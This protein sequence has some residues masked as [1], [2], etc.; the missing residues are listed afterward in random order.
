MTTIAED[1]APLARRRRWE[2][3]PYLLI[4]PT[5]VYLGVFFVWP[6]IQGFGLALRD[7]SGGWTTSAFET[8]VDDAA[9]DDAI[10]FTFL[11][12]LIIVPIQLVLALGMALLLNARLRGGG[13][14]LYIFLLPLAI[15]DL[16]A[17]I[18]WSAIFTE[19]GYLN[20]ILEG[21]GVL[22]QPFIFLDPTSRTQLVIAVAAA[23]IWRSTTF[24]MVILFAGLQAIPKDYT[25]AAEV[26]GAGF[27]QRVRHV[28]FPMLKPSIQVALLLRLIFA[29]EVFAVVIALTG[30]G[31]TVLAAEAYK[32]QATNENEHVAA[33]YSMVILGL[34][35]AAAA[36]VLVALRTPRER[37]LR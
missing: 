28:I 9:F 20:T 7:E 2:G 24:M 27:F 13:L 11:L 23:E 31:A 34:S 19:R 37:R 26:F 4:L 1:T 32:W 35:L 33:A 15:S 6:M 29:F 30:S 16:A 3:L 18:A 12:I 5:V 17:G 8:M 36:V 14:I 22:E 21:V 25:E 10:S